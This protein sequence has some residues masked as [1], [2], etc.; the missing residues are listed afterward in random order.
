MDWMSG[1]DA[2]GCACAR[3]DMR[4]STNRNTSR[5]RGSLAWLILCLQ[6][7]GYRTERLVEDRNDPLFLRVAN[8]WFVDHPPGNQSQEA[9]VFL[10]DLKT[11]A[12]VQRVC[13]YP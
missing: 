1:S 8:F 12:L 2:G 5:V 10:D 13:P 4:G 9:R 3:A 11:D 7:L 6:F